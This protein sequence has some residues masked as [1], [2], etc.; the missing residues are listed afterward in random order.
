MEDAAGD[1]DEGDDQDEFQ[2][3]DDVIGQLR[4]DQVEPENE[5]RGEAEDGGGSEDGI[6]ADEE[7]DGDA[8]GEFSG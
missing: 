8:P 5:R 7:S 1:V 2:R 3:V 4:G 6:D